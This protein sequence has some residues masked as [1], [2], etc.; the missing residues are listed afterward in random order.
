MSSNSITEQDDG[1]RN[2]ILWLSTLAFTL[3]FAVWLM[4]GVLGL[5]VKEDVALMLG[6]SA[7]GMAPAEIKA[8][9]ESR[10]EWLL[11]V[12]ILA[13]ALPRLAFGLWADAI[14]GRKLFVGLLLATA[15]P[16]L[17]LGY[18]TNYWQLLCC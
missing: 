18:A 7:K 14:G 3:L 10:F 11:A 9:I 6:E 13:G 8:A 5:K 4:F 16:T 12:S 15:I 1:A 2:R 17:G